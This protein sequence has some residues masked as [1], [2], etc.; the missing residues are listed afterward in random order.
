MDLRKKAEHELDSTPPSAAAL[1]KPTP[2]PNAFGIG[3]IFD[4]KRVSRDN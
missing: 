2:G 1:V 4:T 3:S